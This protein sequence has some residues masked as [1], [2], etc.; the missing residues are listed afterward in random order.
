MSIAAHHDKIFVALGLRQRLDHRLENLHRSR[1]AHQ[2]G[3]NLLPFHGNELHHG[4]VH[5]GFRSQGLGVE[6]LLRA[7][8][9]KG[10]NA[11]ILRAL[12]LD[13]QLRRDGILH[14]VV[15]PPAYPADQNDT[16]HRP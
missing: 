4:L 9:F 15:N 10:L 7:P 1:S 3:G 12:Q 5:A 8:Y 11:G 2:A 6:L 14:P 13:G 16:Q